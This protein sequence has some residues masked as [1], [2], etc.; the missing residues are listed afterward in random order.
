MK[1]PEPTPAT[2]I[3]LINAMTAILENL[4]EPP[5]YK[6]LNLLSERITF[7]T[8]KL[9][10]ADRRYHALVNFCHAVGIDPNGAYTP[11]QLEEIRGAIDA[12][13]ND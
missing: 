13:L 10:R 3:D 5:N 9:D 11:E 7:L 6:H 1:N 12:I 8:R 2:V 4:Q